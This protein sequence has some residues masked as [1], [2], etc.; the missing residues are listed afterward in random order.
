MKRPWPLFSMLL[1]VLL[2]GADGARAADVYC[3][4][5]GIR[6]HDGGEYQE[7]WYVLNSTVRRTQ[8]PGQTKPTTGCSTSWRSIGAMYRPAEII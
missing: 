3:R 1:V 5:D 8:R 4:H 2:L 7:N 6:I